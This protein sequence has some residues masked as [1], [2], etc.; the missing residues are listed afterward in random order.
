MITIFASTELHTEI[1]ACIAQEDRLDELVSLQAIEDPGASPSAMDIIFLDGKPSLPLDWEQLRPPILLSNQ[2]HWTPNV[3]LGIIFHLLENDR[4]AW[5]YLQDERILDSID[6]QNRLK[7][8]IPFQELTPAET[9]YHAQ[10]NQA[11]TLHYG[12][13]QPIIRTKSPEQYYLA[14]LELAPDGD[15]FA[16]TARELGTLW[17]DQGK[18]VEA[19]KL[20]QKAINGTQ[21]ET[22]RKSLQLLDLKLGMSQLQAP[23]DGVLL[24]SLKQKLWSCLTWF[25]ER[26][27]LLQVAMLLQDACQLANVSE[28][29]AEALGYIQRAIAIFDEEGL[30]ELTASALVQKGILL[31]TWA[32]NDNPQ[33]YRPAIESYQK[34]LYT[35]TKEQHPQS[36]ADIHHKL[37]VLYAEIPDENKKRGIWAGIAS[38][39]FQE[40]LDFYTK[41]SYPYE[42][43]SICNN[44]ANAYMRFPKAIHSD[45][46]VK[47]MHFYEEAL[48]VRSSAWPYERAISL[49]NYLAAAWNAGNDPD[50]FHDARI[51]DMVSKAEEIFTL[52]EDQDLHTEALQHI[53]NLN[54]LREVI[55]KE[56]ADA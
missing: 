13:H 24:E 39:S 52:V 42:Y 10:H 23:I 21:S 34:A 22:A 47:A 48:S 6:L 36:F 11:V 45:N 9:N 7:Y 49:L 46:F 12:L 50:S 27:N 55:A 28:S 40:A 53:E 38:A 15:A 8:G 54:H 19:E 18:I 37:G 31:G 3:L 56:T 32:Q 25:E 17:L 30:H 29:Y 14:A 33:F 16:F 20:I 44:F 4:R 43:G 26:D 2:I 1:E 51:D 5:F 35:F 41:E